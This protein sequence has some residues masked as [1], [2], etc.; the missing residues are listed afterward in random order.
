MTMKIGIDDPAYPGVTYRRGASGQPAPVVRGTGIRVQ[1]IVVAHDTWRL[2]PEQIAAE[3]DIPAPQVR[4]ALAFYQAHRT[5][6]DLGIQAESSVAAQ[7]ER[8]PP[9][10]A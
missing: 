10:A 2:S 8:R 9:R 1:A 5:E 7:Y 6:I 4:E 3:Y